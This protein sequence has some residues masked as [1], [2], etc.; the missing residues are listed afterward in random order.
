[1]LCKATTNKNEPSPRKVKLHASGAAHA[2]PASLARNDELHNAM[3]CQQDAQARKIHNKRAQRSAPLRA[4][5]HAPLR[6][7]LARCAP[8]SA[9]TAQ[10]N[11]SSP[12]Q[13][14]SYYHHPTTHSPA[15]EHPTPTPGS[16]V[17]HAPPS[18][19]RCLRGDDDDGAR[20]REGMTLRTTWVVYVDHC[21]SSSHRRALSGGASSR[22]ADA[23]RARQPR[24]G[25]AHE[26][27]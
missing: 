11:A 25:N 7:P 17:G 27:A 5:L 4:P 16:F 26:S 9:R 1:M 23:E 20:R 8:R 3:P 10:R 22:N 15:N 24:P 13:T 18:V 14:T 19:R 21:S 12:M 6:A 2:T